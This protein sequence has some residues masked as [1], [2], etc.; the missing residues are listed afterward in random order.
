MMEELGQKNM[1]MFREAFSMFSPF[2]KMASPS[3]PSD[4]EKAAATSEVSRSDD[5][6]ALKQQIADMQ[7]K[8]DRMGGN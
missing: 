7:K 4:M 1:E 6:T 5:L 8:L 3:S 2:T